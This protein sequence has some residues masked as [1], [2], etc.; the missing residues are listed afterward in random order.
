[1]AGDWTGDWTGEETCEETCEGTDED[2]TA[3]ACPCLQPLSFASKAVRTVVDA[4]LQTSSQHVASETRFE[5]P[6]RE[7]DSEW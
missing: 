1:M 5:K 2:S 3:S 6:H 4:G 7:P